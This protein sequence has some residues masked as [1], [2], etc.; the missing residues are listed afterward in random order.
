MVQVPG[1]EEDQLLA[2]GV[3]VDGV[4]RARPRGRAQRA[5]EGPLAAEVAVPEAERAWL[6]AHKVVAVVVAP[7]QPLQE[8][9]KQLLHPSLAAFAQPLLHLLLG[10]Q[11]QGPPAGTAQMKD[12]RDKRGHTLPTRRDR[13]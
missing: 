9:P 10:L 3:R 12:T 11:Q 1:A 6:A 4:P 13:H 5:A 8:L 2:A 7:P